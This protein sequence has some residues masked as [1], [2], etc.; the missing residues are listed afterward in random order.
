MGVLCCLVLTSSLNLRDSNTSNQS[1]RYAFQYVWSPRLYE[2]RWASGI[3]VDTAKIEINYDLG[4]TNYEKF[5]F[6][7]TKSLAGCMK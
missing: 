1:V 3:K 7:C 5:Y 6:D 2:P 4:I